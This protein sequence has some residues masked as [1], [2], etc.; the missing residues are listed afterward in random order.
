MSLSLAISLSGGVWC[1]VNVVRL[2]VCF[3]GIVYV[4]ANSETRTD[5]KIGSESHQRFAF[6][7]GMFLQRDRTTED[8]E[9][10]RSRE[11]EQK[12]LITF[13]CLIVI[14]LLLLHLRLPHP[15][16]LFNTFLWM[17]LIW[18]CV[19]CAALDCVS[20]FSIFFTPSII[21]VVFG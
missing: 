12:L 11:R 17:A 3:L 6:A 19:A 4:T 7:V 18:R 16:G 1:A 20:L 15:S 13:Y 10:S 8:W 14:R 2:C 9:S 21:F 5:T